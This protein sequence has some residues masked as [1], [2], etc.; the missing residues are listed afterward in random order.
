MQVT[1]DTFKESLH[2]TEVYTYYRSKLHNTV[3]CDTHKGVRYLGR[4]W[5]GVL[6]QQQPVEQWWHAA[7]MPGAA[8]GPECAPQLLWQLLGSEPAHWPAAVRTHTHTHQATR[9]MTAC[10]HDRHSGNDS[11]N[12][13]Q[14]TLS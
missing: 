8:P 3:T 13:F 4:P 11:S 5:P 6:Q 10:Y 7:E 12:T 9:D 2:V 1:T 14:C